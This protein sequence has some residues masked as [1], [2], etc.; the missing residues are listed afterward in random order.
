MQNQANDLKLTTEGLTMKQEAILGRIATLE[1]I[2][3]KMKRL[4]KSMC[5][6]DPDDWAQT[7]IIGPIEVVVSKDHGWAHA[8]T[9]VDDWLQKLREQSEE[10]QQSIGL[11]AS[12]SP[13]KKKATKPT[14]DTE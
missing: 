8:G 1:R 2:Q 6:L 7:Y 13:A 3:A 4:I 12:P 10:L 11:P 5:K 9:T 14:E